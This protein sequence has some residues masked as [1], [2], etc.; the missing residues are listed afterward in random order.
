[1]RETVNAREDG[2][3]LGRVRF[4][5]YRAGTRE[6]LSVSPW[7]RNLILASLVTGWGLLT[8]RMTGDT[9]KDLIVT[10]GEIGTSSTATTEGM[11]ALV[12]PTVTGILVANTSRTAKQA[13]LT[14]FI[15]DGSLP[16]GTYREFLMRMGSAAFSRA[17][18][19]SPYIKASGEDTGVEYEVNFDNA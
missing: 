17:V 11:T 8:A 18:A 10:S 6:V 7:S 15:P 13:L 2:K 4:V 9:T 14:F 1:M 3:G 16:N 12:A 19:A 5:K